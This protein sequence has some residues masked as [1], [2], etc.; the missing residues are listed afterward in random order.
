MRIVINTRFLLSKH[1]EGIGRFT[2]EVAQRLVAQ[3]PDDDFIFLFDRSFEERFIYADNVTPVIV[4][5]PARHPLLWWFWFES[6]LPSILR[7]QQADVFLSPDAYCSLRTDVPTVMVTHDIAHVHY[8]QQ[9]PYLVN[10]YYQHFVP[11]FLKRADHIVTVSGHGAKDIHQVYGTPWEKISV[12]CNGC[13][14]DFR[15]LS[16]IEVIDIRQRYSD[17]QPYFFYLGAVHPRKNVGR[18]IQAFNDFKR[19][20]DSPIK[21]LIGGR[22]AWQTGDVKQAYEQSPYKADIKLLGYIA[23]EDLP[24]LVGSA[25]ALTYVSLFEGFGV[26]LLE[27]MHAEVPIL[28]SDVSSMPEIAGAAGLHVDPNDEVA[29]TKGMLQLWQD[30]GLRQQLILAARKQRGQF[31]WEYAT[32]VVEEAMVNVA[33]SC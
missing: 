27:A 8:P 13:N 2:H 26:P 3:R 28:T 7:Q 12:A 33:A 31:S 20:S 19:Q 9:I 18:L 32:K 30:S 1:L 10:K 21:L 11:R 25:L 23:D 16:D 17:G 14:A 24:M 15:P 22:L 4:S 29:I 5:P 6:R